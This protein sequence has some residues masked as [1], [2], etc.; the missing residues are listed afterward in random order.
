[1]LWEGE[2]CKQ[3]C[4]VTCSASHMLLRYP[5]AAAALQPQQC[6]H[7]APPMQMLRL[8]IVDPVER[9]QEHSAASSHRRFEQSL[10]AAIDRLRYASTRQARGR[11]L[12]L[13]RQ[14]LRTRQQELFNATQRA[15]RREPGTVSCA[16]FGGS[17]G[18]K[19]SPTANR[20]ERGQNLVRLRGGFV[21]GAE[22]SMAWTR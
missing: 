14:F 1:M 15:S 12:A 21:P 10:G 18:T 9:R 6:G 20:R 13:L 3:S 7:I 19:R 17:V 16:P 4:C 22:T 2:G 11:Q 5:Q 8:S